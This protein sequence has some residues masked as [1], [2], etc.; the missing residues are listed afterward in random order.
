MKYRPNP[1]LLVNQ[2]LSG[3]ELISRAV[4]WNLDFRQ[5]DHGPLIARAVVFG[6]DDIDEYLM[7]NQTE[8]RIL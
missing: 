8:S 7:P 5:I 2:G 6:H 3:T 4:N 1:K